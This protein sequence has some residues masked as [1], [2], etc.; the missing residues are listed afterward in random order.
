[1]LNGH[2]LQQAL[3]VA[4]VLG[5][6]DLLASRCMN[7]TELAIATRVD[8]PSLLRLLRASGVFS[9]K[10]DTPFRTHAGRGHPADGCSELGS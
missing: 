5:I 1:M 10:S 6:A 8:E 7:A 3:Y 4:A 2:C 9:E